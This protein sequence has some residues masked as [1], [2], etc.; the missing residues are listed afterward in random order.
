MRCLAQ[1]HHSGVGKAIEHSSERRI[2][3]I[4]QGLGGIADH[5]RQR[6]GFDERVCP[7]V[8]RPAVCT[9]Q[10]HKTDLS[11]IALF[12]FLLAASRHT[13]QPLPI[14]F[15]Q[16]HH[17]PAADRELIAQRLGYLGSPRRSKWHRTA[18]C[19]A[20]PG[21]RR[22]CVSRHCRSRAPP[23]V[24]VPVQQ[25]A[26]GALSHRRDQRCGSSRRP[27]NPSPRRYRAARWSAP[28]RSAAA[29]PHTRIPRAIANTARRDLGFNHRFA[30]AG[31]RRHGFLLKPN[32][33][34]RA[35]KLPDLVGV[36]VV[37]AH[38]N[39]SE[40]DLRAPTGTRFPPYLFGAHS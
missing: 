18:P 38:R 28:P 24:C 17:E 35:D 1:Q 5:G 30:E 19:P 15:A 7:P 26:H 31:S 11:E 4:G 20:S 29:Y 22:R 16:R 40:A 14:G 36:S 6:F 9:N 37:N 21:C 10:R 23:S 33:A 12:K 8:F 2:V 39:G 32:N 27:H 3:D 25:A 34:R 13:D